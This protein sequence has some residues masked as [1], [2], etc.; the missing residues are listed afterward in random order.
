MVASPAAGRRALDAK[1]VDAL[2]LL[3]QDRL[4]FRTNVDA[5][6]A[7]IADTAVRA[8]RNHLP[9]APELTTATLHPPDKKTTDAESLVA[10]AR[11][12]CSCSCRSRST[13]SG[14]VSGVVEEKSNRVV[15]I[16]LS[17]VRPRHLL[18]G[19]VIGI[20]LLGLA[21][22]ALVAGLAAT[23][24]AAGV[25]DAPAG[26]RRQRRARHPLVRARVRAL[27]GRLRRRRRARLPAAGR[28]HGGAAGHATRS[29]PPTSPAT[30][31]SRR[32]ER[33]RSRTSSPSSRSPRRSSCPP[34]ARSSACRSGNTYSRSCSSSPRSTRSS[35]S[36][37]ASTATA[38]SAA[39]P[40]S[41]SAPRGASPGTHTSQK[42]HHDDR[43][44][45]TAHARPAPHPS[46]ALSAVAS[47]S[48]SG[49]TAAAAVGFLVPYVFAD[50]LDVPR[51]AYYAI[52]VSAVASFFLALDA[53]ERA[54][55]AVDA[56][57]ELASWALLLG[58]LAGALLAAIALGYGST[59]H[60]SGPGVL[61][62]DRLAGHR[63]R[64]GRRAPAGRVPRARRLHR[65][66]VPA[67]PRARRSGRPA[68]ARSRSSRRWRSPRRTTSATRTSAARR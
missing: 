35:A 41:A 45:D 54:L 5:K 29:S 36:P 42:G 3:S 26:A 7:A 55:S 27:R 9:P 8:L 33:P 13:A 20:G 25:F 49:S 10:Y 59:P 21:Q 68:P 17:T 60:P 44:A 34:A 46:P 6:A 51:D 4:V 24:L 63:L 31:R 12:A 62:R 66:P 28:E 16:I 58:A 22:L 1:K 61:R 32:H 30:S 48:C 56:D 39:G 15:E 11:L 53:R 50:R 40:D 23:L 47:V 38:S 64:S 2:L 14:C 18:A 67:R 43:R 52:Y 37:A 19:K 65:V 57:A